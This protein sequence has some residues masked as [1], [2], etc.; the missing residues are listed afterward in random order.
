MQLIDKTLYFWHEKGGFQAARIVAFKVDRNQKLTSITVRR[1]NGAK[2]RKLKPEAW[3]SRPEVC[4]VL[5][6]GKIRPVPAIP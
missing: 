4:G 6:R 2:P 3:V 1:N 5:Y